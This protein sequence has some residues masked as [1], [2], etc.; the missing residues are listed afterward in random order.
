MRSK[1]V[2]LSRLEF[3]G[4][5]LI[6]T[7]RFLNVVTVLTL[8]FILRFLMTLLALDSSRSFRHYW[9]FHRWS[10]CAQ[11]SNRPS[12]FPQYYLL[13]LIG[14]TR[15]VLNDII[16]LQQSFDFHSFCRVDRDF[17]LSLLLTILAPIN[18][19]LFSLKKSAFFLN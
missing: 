5:K 15:S 7:V 11:R 18:I 8:V 12:S 3:H 13:A 10:S 19:L 1:N 6:L 14:D 2:L 16:S 17:L 9:S 4:G